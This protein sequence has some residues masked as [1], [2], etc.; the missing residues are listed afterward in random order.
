MS[1]N[2]RILGDR[3]LPHCLC[4]LEGIEHLYRMKSAGT[5]PLDWLDSL[6]LRLTTNHGELWYRDH[7][8]VILET[9]M[10]EYFNDQVYDDMKLSETTFPTIEFKGYSIKERTTSLNHI[11]NYD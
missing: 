4:V 11:F 7:F 1:A 5:L 2:S 3:N 8:P 10:S 6:L 9:N